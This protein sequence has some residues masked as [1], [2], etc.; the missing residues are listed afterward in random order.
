MER[1]RWRGREKRERN[2]EDA[3]RGGGE[4]AVNEV[5][6]VN[7]VGGEIEEEKSRRSSQDERVWREGERDY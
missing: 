1:T 2:G 5:K 6:S 3:R 7:N 4:N